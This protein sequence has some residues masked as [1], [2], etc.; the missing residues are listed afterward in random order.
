MRF[1]SL[2]TTVLTAFDEILLA[3]RNSF[4]DN[5]SLLEMKN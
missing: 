4:S 5:L 3:F 1:K 2:S